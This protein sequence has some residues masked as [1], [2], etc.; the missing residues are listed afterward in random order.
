MARQYSL[1]RPSAGPASGIN[2]VAALNKEQYVAVSS[3]PGKAL[4]GPFAG[5]EGLPDSMEH[6]TRVASE[7]TDQALDKVLRIA[8]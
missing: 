4:V 7:P 8:R 1:H 6:W 2:Y 5:L 3:P